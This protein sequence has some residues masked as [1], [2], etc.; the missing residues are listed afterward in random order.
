MTTPAAPGCPVDESFDP[1]APEFLADSYAVMAALPNQGAPLFF[2]PSIGYYIVTRYRDIEAVFHD[3]GNYS[4]APAQEPL[5][6]LVAEAQQILLAGGHKPQPS[7]VRTSS[8]SD[9]VSWW[10]PVS[11]GRPSCRHR[12]PPRSMS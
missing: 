12:P 10:K 5:V 1:L 8:R 2:A 7:P 9:Y 6:P 11:C 4:A 3:P